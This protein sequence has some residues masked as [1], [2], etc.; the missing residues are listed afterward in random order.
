M[1]PDKSGLWWNGKGD[2]RFLHVSSDLVYFE[3]GCI[4]QLSHVG[5]HYAAMPTRDEWEAAMAELEAL[6]AEVAAL[7]GDK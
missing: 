3:G 6:R 5:D 4:V 1:R 7:R 2:I